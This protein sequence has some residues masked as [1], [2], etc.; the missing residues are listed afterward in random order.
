MKYGKKYVCNFYGNLF[1]QF[2]LKYYYTMGHV[3]E[4]ME[5][6][7]P[8][9][10]A[11]QLYADYFNSSSISKH[12]KNVIGKSSVK[13]VP[14]CYFYPNKMDYENRK[15]YLTTKNY[16]PRIISCRVLI[17]KILM[18]LLIILCHY[19][20]NYSLKIQNFYVE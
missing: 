15:D 13:I 7:H 12:V 1:Q 3:S 14:Y 2:K 9:L 5:E 4:F 16:L 20:R 17:L 19:I 18:K 11:S 10:L 6:C 8:F